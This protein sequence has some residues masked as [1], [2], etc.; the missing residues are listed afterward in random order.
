[1]LDGPTVMFSDGNAPDR[2]DAERLVTEIRE[3]LLRQDGD[4]N[5]G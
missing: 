5:G 1:M 3:M 4:R 2:E